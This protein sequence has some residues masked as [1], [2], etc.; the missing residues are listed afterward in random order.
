MPRTGRPHRSRPT[1][2]RIRSRQP[3][4]LPVP[5]LHSRGR[6]AV[7]GSHQ[8]KRGE[9]LSTTRATGPVGTGTSR[10]PLRPVGL[11]TDAL[12]MVPATRDPRPA[13]RRRAGVSSCQQVL[14]V[15]FLR[16]NG[17]IGG[18]SRSC[19]CQRGDAAERHPPSCGVRGCGPLTGRRHYLR[20][21]IPAGPKARAAAAKAIRR[22]AGQVDE[23]RH[24]RT[25]APVDQL[26]N[27]YLQT[28]RRRAHN[29]SD[30]QPVPG[31]ARPAVH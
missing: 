23:Q 21:V 9:G 6:E 20:E 27:R 29:A 16:G 30:V 5:V 17:I 13:P 2:G 11:W 4:S 19:P 31:E 3:S 24:P 18:A 12:D 15:S 7:V 26:L 25:N 14:I 28:L 10:L 8:K 1:D 22:V